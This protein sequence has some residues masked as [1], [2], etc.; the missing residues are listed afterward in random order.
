MGA[1]ENAEK[2]TLGGV[3]GLFPVVRDGSFR[4][5]SGR[6]RLQ[7]ARELGAE[8]PQVMIRC[9]DDRFALALAYVSNVQ[10]GLTPREERAVQELGA[11]AAALLEPQ[12]RGLR[13]LH[14]PHL[15]ALKESVTRWGYQDYPWLAIIRDQHGRI[16]SGR[17]R[18]ATARALGINWRVVTLEVAD[19][20]AALEIALAANRSEG[21]APPTLRRL[22][23]EGILSASIGRTISLIRLYLREHPTWSTQ[24][25]ALDLVH[26]QSA[27]EI[28]EM[29]AL[30]RS[31]RT[32]ER[33]RGE[34]AEIAPFCPAPRAWFWLVP[35]LVPSYPEEGPS[36]RSRRPA[37]PS[38]KNAENLEGGRW[39]QTRARIRAA[40][41]ENPR[42]SDR[43]IGRLVDASDKTVGAVRREMEESAE[44]VRLRGG[45]GGGAAGSTRSIST[46]PRRCG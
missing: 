34:N 26:S 41:R 14:P 30:V 28:A 10:R 36:P 5:L 21:W 40:L 46:A 2:P 19:D 15:A 12:A 23:R 13:P 16:L 42:R 3:C 29:T 4:I 25:I 39:A 18:S 43:A 45:R 32:A 33:E 11:G 6:Q 27:H 31:V 9:D 38:Q 24:Q 37:R 1:T 17:H 7:V 35:P 22:E 44:I 20:G 8:W